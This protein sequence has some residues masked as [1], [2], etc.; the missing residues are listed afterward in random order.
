MD[1]SLPITSLQNPRVKRAVKLR[2]HTHRDEL[3]L[4]L[5][6]G[7]REIGRALDNGRR[8]SELFYCPE[9][10]QNVHNEELLARAKA[11]GAALLNCV[12]AVFAKLSY[13]DRPDGLLAVA[14]RVKT[15]LDALN[16]PANALIVVVESIEKPGNLGTILR[17]SDAAGVDAVIVC[18]RCTDVDN[19]N[20]VRASIGTLFSLPVVETDSASALAWLRARG[21]RILAATPHAEALYSDC[22][23]RPA[24][25]VVVG[26]EQYGLSSAWMER[27]DAR[28]RIPMRGQADSLNVAQAATI[29]L[30]EALRQRANA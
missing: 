5:V 3:G 10:F 23:M 19:P 29:L 22:N 26:A 28:V 4:M 9:L 8:L 12:A 17:T 15:P 7:Y 20:V 21:I 18:D 25:A 6:E 24:T 30:F 27:A 2:R 1:E 11:D 13:R 16:P 14:P